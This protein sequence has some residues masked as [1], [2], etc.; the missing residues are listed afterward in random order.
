MSMRSFP[1]V[2]AL[3][4]LIGQRLEQVQ[5]N[6]FSLTLVFDQGDTIT[7]EYRVEYRDTDGIVSRYAGAIFS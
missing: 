5:L 1:P 3:N 6:V 2:A 4:F 7:S